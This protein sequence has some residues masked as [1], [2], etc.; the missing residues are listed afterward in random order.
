MKSK[1]VISLFTFGIFLVVAGALLKIFKNP[2]AN[3]VMAIG[4][5]FELMAGLLF[6]WN[7]I[8]KK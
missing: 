5:A 6:I 3:L 1:K 7:K 2:Q 8:Q 4:L